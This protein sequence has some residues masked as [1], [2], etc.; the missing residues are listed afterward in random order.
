MERSCN[1]VLTEL[2]FEKAH[3]NQADLL[4]AFEQ[5]INAPKL[6]STPLDLAGAIKEIRNN[7]YYF[8]KHDNE[9]IGTAAYCI[10]EDGSCYISNMAIAPNYRGLGIARYAMKF[11]MEKCTDAWR[12]DLIT[13]PEN[14]RSI[15][16]YESFGFKVESRIENY[17]G[18]GEPRIIMAKEKTSKKEF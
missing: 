18:D 4:V 14:F 3:E 11:L 8:I 1:N 9:M 15:P 17:Y 16:L 12:V 13:H 2:I 7:I 6:Y 5:I 10:R